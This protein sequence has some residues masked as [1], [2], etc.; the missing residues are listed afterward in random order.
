MKLLWAFFLISLLFLNPI[1]IEDVFGEH[2][3]RNASGF[4][5]R[6]EERRLDYIRSNERYG[7]NFN[8]LKNFNLDECYETARSDDFW[9]HWKAPIFFLIFFGILGIIF[10][11]I[12]N[13][14]RQTRAQTIE[15][16]AYKDLPRKPFPLWVKQSTLQ[17]QDGKCNMCGIP[18]N[19]YIA[20]Y[21][22]ADND[23]TNNQPS[24]CQALCANCH[25]EKTKLN[26]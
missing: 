11:I 6:Q 21:D 7:G 14:K 2:W 9:M 4:C 15:T 22:H 26:R 13:A 18:L 10:G 23:K 20:Q 19:N 3:Y 5:D 8:P 16:F 1:I 25:S 24:N 17:N 12:F